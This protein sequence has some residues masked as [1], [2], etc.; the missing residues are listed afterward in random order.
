MSPFRFMYLTLWK[1]LRRCRTGTHGTEIWLTLGCLRGTRWTRSSRLRCS[2]WHRERR[3]RYGG[4]RSGISPSSRRHRTI[5]KSENFI[6]RSSRWHHLHDETLRRAWHRN[7]HLDALFW[8]LFVQYGHVTLDLGFGFGGVY[9]SRPQVRYAS[10][11]CTILVDIWNL[12]GITLRLALSITTTST[13][14]SDF[15]VAANEKTQH[16]YCILRTSINN[17]FKHPPVLYEHCQILSRYEWFKRSFGI[18]FLLKTHFEES[19]S[20]FKEQWIG[21]ET[22]NVFCLTSYSLS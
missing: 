22:R 17:S 20:K 8:T 14:A 12:K 9:G 2:L 3:T 10:E 19:R 16:L 7:G 13:L 4:S 11:Y 5:C 18:F 21:Y 6:F 1:P 15:A